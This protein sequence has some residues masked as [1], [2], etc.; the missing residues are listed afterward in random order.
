MEYAESI[1]DLVGDTPLVRISR[2]TRDLG[3]ADRQP[4]LLAKLEM[5]N[6]GGSVKDRI[7]LPMIEAAERAGLLKPGGTIIEPTSG[8]HRPRPG[9]RGRAQGLSLHLRDGRQAV[10]RE[11][12]PAA[13]VR[14]R[15]RAV[16]DQRRARVARELLLGR[17]AARPR[18]PG[19]VQARP[20]LEPGEPGRPRA[21]D[22]ARDLGR[23]PRAG[24]RT[25]WR[26]VGT[27][28]TVSGIAR[29]L[30]AQNPSITVVGADPEG[31]VLS[32]DTARPYLTEG[33]GRGLLPGHVRPGGGR[34][35]GAGL[36]PRR[37]RDGP[38]DHAR[39]GDPGRRV[40]RDGDGRRARRGRAG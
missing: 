14:R 34:P 29:Y 9:D 8:Q 33:V 5:L 4:L 23:R 16:P 27:G 2:L 3:P 19:R 12:G 10:G 13:R 39:G 31:S 1:L 32:G 7:G 40:V 28:G 18:H 15:G 25:S 38:P 21:D 17:R 6:P 30:R 26:R 24:S 35:L 11:A 22:R 36:R 20:V 37:V